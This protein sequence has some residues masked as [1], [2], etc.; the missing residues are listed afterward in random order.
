MTPLSS[1]VPDTDGSSIHDHI[2]LN[3]QLGIDSCSVRHCFTICLSLC[4][5]NITKNKKITNYTDPQQFS[6]SKRFIA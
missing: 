3:F 4:S 5:K 6:L 2:L 1:A